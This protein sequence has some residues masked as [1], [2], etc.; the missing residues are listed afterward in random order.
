MEPHLTL[1]QRLPD[2]PARTE[3]VEVYRPLAIGLAKRYA[4][5]GQDLDDLIQVALLGLVKAI[6]RFDTELGHRFVSFAVPTI[7]GEL[8]RF[9]RDA[10][11]SVGV[12][13]RMKET[14]IAART[15]NEQ[16]SQRLGRSPSIA[17][18]A[19]HIGSSID[20]VAEAATLTSAYRA[21]SLNDDNGDGSAIG[22][23]LL[24]STD[25]GIEL[26]EDLHALRP[27]LQGRTARER[28]ILYLRFYRDLT[29]R[30]IA[31]EVGMSQMNV[32]RVLSSSLEKLRVLLEV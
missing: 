30:E 18:I 13:R 16:L 27:L 23:D 28:E 21:Y 31:D 4:H 14:S 19:E 8:K 11:W 10:G 3:L 1:F 7:T 32:S 9:F 12:P 29:Q 26:F 2:A 6:D 22:I 20:E 5:R 24:G 17:E 15:A 25:P